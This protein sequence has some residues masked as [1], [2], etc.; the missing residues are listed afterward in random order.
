MSDEQDQQSYSESIANSASVTALA[1]LAMLSTPLLLAL[2]GFLGLGY[3]DN[4]FGMQEIRVAT[5]ERSVNEAVGNASD[6][7]QKLGAQVAVLD[8]RTT[9][10]EAGRA[11]A[12]RAADIRNEQILGRLD[13]MESATLELAKQVAALAAIMQTMQAS[14]SPQQRLMR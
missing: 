6:E 5:V 10:I 9:V 13:R 14:A 4:R 8:T 3:L 2:I 11:E 12:R 1:R 7:I